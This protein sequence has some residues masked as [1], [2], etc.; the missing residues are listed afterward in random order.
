MPRTLSGL[1]NAEFDDITCTS[2][3]AVS[4][5]IRDL[6]IGGTLT[7]SIVNA[8][9]FGELSAAPAVCTNLDLRNPIARSSRVRF[10]GNPD[11]LHI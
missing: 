10:R 8:D 6:D 7:T 3:V 4:A 2:L 11:A 9:S 1:S 5:D